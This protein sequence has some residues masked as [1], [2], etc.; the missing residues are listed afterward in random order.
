MLLAFCPPL[1]T[2]M[3]ISPASVRPEAR[4]VLFFPVQFLVRG[5]PKVLLVS[6]VPAVHAMHSCAETELSNDAGLSIHRTSK[7]GHR[8]NGGLSQTV[9]P[10][11]ERSRRFEMT[12]DPMFCE[13]IIQFLGR[14][15][16]QF[17]RAF[18]R[19]ATNIDWSFWI[20]TVSAI[21]LF[22]ILKTS[23]LVFMPYCQ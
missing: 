16:R 13:V 17:S 23:S 1:L 21:H 2:L 18:I 12:L 6:G 5:I 4:Y 20:L 9:L 15:L 11:L 22:G 14:V 8:I 10:L 19:T 3:H 7:H